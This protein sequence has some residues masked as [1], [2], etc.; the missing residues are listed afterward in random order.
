LLCFSVFV[1]GF[2]TNRSANARYTYNIGAKFIE[3]AKLHKLATCHRADYC[4]SV[5]INACHQ[6]QWCNR[7]AHL[8]IMGKYT[9]VV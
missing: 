2:V 1:A 5:L 6:W 7:L 8:L 9:S 3:A 4:K